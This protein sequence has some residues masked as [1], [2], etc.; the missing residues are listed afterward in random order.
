MVPLLLYWINR[1]WLLASR[2]ELH[3]DP[4]IF[5]LRDKHSLLIGLGVLGIVVLA[6]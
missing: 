6:L 1:V 5:A 2:A 4:V 3:E